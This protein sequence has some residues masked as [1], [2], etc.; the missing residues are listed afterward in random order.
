MSCAE[1]VLEDAKYDSPLFS[2]LCHEG[3]LN[4]EAR[5]LKLE[6]RMLKLEV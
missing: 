3:L 4:L 6:A 1:V 2:L 5:M